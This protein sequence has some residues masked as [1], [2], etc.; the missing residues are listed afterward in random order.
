MAYPNSDLLV[1]IRQSQ[2]FA[3]EASFTC[4]SGELLAL[5]GPSG[6]GKSTLLRMIA[7]LAKPGAGQIVCN[8]H[9]WFDA[10]TNRF[11]SP[12]QR[13][14]GYVPQHYGLFPH[15]TAVE[16]I[17]AGLHTLATEERMS[18]AHAWL[19]RMHLTGLGDRK[20]AE[21]SG[22]QQQRVAVARALAGDPSIL[23]LDEP[24]SA[25]DSATREKLHGELAE[26]K[27]QL[28]IPILLV[29]H[30]L[31]EALLLA[32]RIALLDHGKTLQAGIPGEIMMRPATEEAAKLIGLRNLFDGEVV[33]HVR[34]TPATL[35]R[36]GSHLLESAYR[37]EFQTGG[38]VR[39]AIPESGIRFRPIARH[40]PVPQQNLIEVR[41]GKLLA[42]GN[43]TRLSL[44]VE[45]EASPLRVTIPRRLA[46]ELTLVEGQVVQIN[47]RA[48][49]IHLFP[50]P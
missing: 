25:V 29:T 47:L 32:D 24:F 50:N 45:G 13:G 9:V 10:V 40:A 43:E 14:I 26:L 8:G 31:T 37:P 11:M 20:P 12:Q 44:L 17:C 48:E 28:A 3:M 23:L 38:A 6:G 36:F 49:D 46:E 42:L 7:G 18:R 15:M 34:E 27:A 35:L 4:A 33:D 21:L 5:V 39:W 30:D 22:G 2:P 16:N 19:A 1:D 41:V